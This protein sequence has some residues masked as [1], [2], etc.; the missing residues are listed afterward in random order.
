MAPVL[1]AVSAGEYRLSTLFLLFIIG[2]FGHAYGFALNDYLDIKIDRGS[3][4]L[5]ER[6][7][8]RGSIS[9]KEALYFIFT[10]MLFAFLLCAIFFPNITTLIILG[11]SSILVTLYNLINKKLPGVDVILAASIFTLVL[12]GG[13]APKNTVESLTYLIAGMGAVQVL[14]MNAV[15]GGLKDIE[16]DKQTLSKTSASSLGVAIKNKRLEISHKFRICAFG[17]EAFHLSLAFVP[18]IFLQL[19]YHLWLISLLVIVSA[20]ILYLTKLILSIE[21]FERQR[22]RR[23]VGIHYMV[24]YSLAP[25]VLASLS[26][27]ILFLIIIPPAFFIGS[28]LVLHRTYLN[29]QT[30]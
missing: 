11:T 14:F 15:L 28:N 5:S 19:P 13:Y 20:I 29:P 2:C 8:V 30:M 4:E 10:S 17:I 22:L 3:L 1:G 25:L 27:Y 23:L 6:P 12:F 24:S 9:R 26:F 21:H 7:L 18:F 16:H